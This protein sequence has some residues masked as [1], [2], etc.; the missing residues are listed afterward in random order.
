MSVGYNRSRALYGE[1]AMDEKTQ[2]IAQLND[3][4]RRTLC[5]GGQVML[6]SGIAAMG[7]EAK[8]EVLQGFRLFNDFNPGN[9]PHGERDFI[10]FIARGTQI[11]AKCDYYDLDMRY[12]SDDPSDPL[13]TK[14]VWTIMLATEY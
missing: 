11:F 2:K 3:L 10:S 8:A 6:S 7:E 14:R 1:R 9:N 5:Q 13:I 4:L 12:L